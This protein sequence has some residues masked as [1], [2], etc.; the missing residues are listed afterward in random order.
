MTAKLVLRPEAEQEILAAAEW[1]EDRAP[2]LAAEFLRAVDAAIAS[3]QRNPLQQPA[4]DASMRQVLL[5]RF[6]F[7][8]VYRTSGDEVVVAGCVHWRQQPRQWLNRQ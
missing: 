1:Y 2:G 3:I 6:P 5:R 7:S 4:I 8:L